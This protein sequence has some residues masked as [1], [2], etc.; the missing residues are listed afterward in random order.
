MTTEAQN[1]HGMIKDMAKNGITIE[2]AKCLAVNLLPI[3]TDEVEMAED[4]KYSYHYIYDDESKLIIDDEGY[5]YCD[6]DT[7]INILCDIN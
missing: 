4:G 1:V 2:R 5:V 6:E 3:S 7:E